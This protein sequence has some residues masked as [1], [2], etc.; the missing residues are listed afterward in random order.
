MSVRFV[1]RLLFGGSAGRCLV[2]RPIQMTIRETPDGW[3]ATAQLREIGPT[4]GLDH[5]V[6]PM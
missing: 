1:E 5:G 6:E 4:E 3:R 2:E